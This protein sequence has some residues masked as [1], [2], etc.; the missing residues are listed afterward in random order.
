M[1]IK[2][3]Q[4]AAIAVL[5]FNNLSGQQTENYFCTGFV[6][7]L[8]TELCR[9]S[10]LQVISPGT[11]FTFDSGSADFSDLG[12]KFDIS[13]FLKGGIRRQRDT[14]RINAELIDSNHQV[15]WAERYDTPADTVF[16]IQ[17]EIIDRVSSALTLNIDATRLKAIRT[18]PTSELAAYDCWLKGFEFLQQGT[19]EADTTARET[20]NQALSID[21]NYSRAYAGLAL[22]YFNEWN[23]QHWANWDE[24]EQKSYEYALRASNLDE[25]DHI[26]QLVLGKTLLFR[27][28]FDQAE[29]AFEKAIALNPNDTNSLI[30]IAGCMLYLGQSDKGVELVKKVLRLNPYCDSWYYAFA[31]LPYF[32]L[33]R[34]DEA[35]TLVAKAADLTFVDI[36][37]YIACG[38]A[39]KGDLNE[40]RR[41]IEQFKLFFKEKITF[42]REPEEGEALRWIMH[43]NPFKYEADAEHLANDL[44]MAGLDG[45]YTQ[46]NKSTQS[47]TQ[48]NSDI[49]GDQHERQTT[50]LA[51]HQPATNVIGNVFRR[52]GDTW[53]LTFASDTVYLSEVKGFH[54]LTLLLTKPND[55]IHCSDLMGI[56]V[57]QE[58]GDVTI[59]A[60]ARSAYENHI[61]DLQE[62]LEEAEENNDIGHSELLR[63]ELDQVVE[64]LS[65]ALGLS[66]R[67]RKLSAPSDRA[68]SAVTWRI[69]HAILKITSAHPLLGKHLK[70]TIKTGTFCS[71]QCDEGIRWS[72]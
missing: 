14:L 34:Y 36:P 46:S 61:R 17:D 7:D 51:T 3:T 70:Q 45:A 49:E 35:F 39:Y 71:Y 60:Q 8:V 69:R 13:Y 54:D 25:N 42:G 67:T 57:A 63:E 37:A 65:K 66:G 4:F 53:Q 47:G 62:Q 72:L 55:E 28:Q 21:P 6:L 68:R 40:A 43:V 11:S 18:K 2:S 9:F 19:V 52:N 27:R 41:L 56:P 38:H 1:K 20:F 22:S 23:C 26:S 31:S 5:P 48:Q 12:K 59:D 58:Q 32:G 64:H 15:L 24:N 10:N 29:K 30:Q 16:D 50:G 44:T 33:K